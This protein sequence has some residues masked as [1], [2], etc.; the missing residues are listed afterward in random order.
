M[1]H[2]IESGRSDS[3]HRLKAGPTRVA[4]CVAHRVVQLDFGYPR[5]WGFYNISGRLDLVFFLSYG[6]QSGSWG[7]ILKSYY[8]LAA[9]PK[10]LQMPNIFS[11]KQLLS[12]VAPSTVSQ[13]YSLP[14]EE[15]AFDYFFH[16]IIISHSSSLFGFLQV[17]ALVSKHVRHQL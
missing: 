10:F 14:G 9:F 2:S 15:V 5:E 4:H 12:Q 7:H 11:V 8:F 16:E 1:R 13:S 17:V 6:K 3:S